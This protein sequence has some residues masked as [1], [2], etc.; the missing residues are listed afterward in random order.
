M[1]S[2]LFQQVISIHAPIVGCDFRLCP[3]G[4]LECKFQSTHPSW[5]A[6][7]CATVLIALISISIH[8]PI[9]GCDTMGWGWSKFW[10]ISIHAPI[11]GCDTNQQRSPFLVCDFNPRT[12]RGVR[13]TVQTVFL[14][15]REFQ[16]THPSWGATVSYLVNERK[17]D[18]SIHAPIVGCDNRKL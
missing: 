4:P 11:V 9:V 15:T 16:S 2:W 12:H 18:I 7:V 1:I 14:G 6:T 3:C 13:Q 8:A 5:G 10:S 17:A